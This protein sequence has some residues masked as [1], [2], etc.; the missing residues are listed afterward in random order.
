MTLAWTKQ[1][2]EVSVRKV[3]ARNYDADRTIQRPFRHTYVQV[4]SLQICHVLNR[5]FQAP[6]LMAVLRF[7]F[8]KER[9]EVSER[10]LSH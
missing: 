5:L 8:G 7:V 3:H 4:E 2:L 6:V 9:L 1:Q 10:D